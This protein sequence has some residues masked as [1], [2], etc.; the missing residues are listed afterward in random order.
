MKPTRL[1]GVLAASISGLHAQPEKAPAPT[2]PATDTYLRQTIE[3]F[4]ILVDPRLVKQKDLCAATLKEV[5]SQLY[6][7]SRKVPS[8]PL[9]KLRQVR[10]FVQLRSP[11]RCAV[12]HPSRRW[13]SRHRQ[14]PDMARCIELSHPKAILSWSKQ[15]P[16][17]LLH[18]LA[19]A[20][21]H[22]F[23]AGG[24]DNAEVRKCFDEAVKNKKYASVLHIQGHTQRAYA[25]TNH[26]EYFAEACE[27]F[28]GTNDMYPFVKSELQQH[29]PK[30]AKLLG[31]LW[32]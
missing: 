5:G 30:L 11:T 21:H 31:T 19:H 14:N 9:R 25:L 2:W 26:K 22:Q 4:P 18:E 10:I 24:F 13:L 32:R 23:L 7:V 3:G 1:L 27:A 17:M 28:F 29:D 20:Y 12:Y 8:K 15:Q 16:W 6:Q